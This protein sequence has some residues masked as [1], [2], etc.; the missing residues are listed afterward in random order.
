M[1]NARKIYTVKEQIENSHS[2]RSQVEK[3]YTQSAAREILSVDAETEFNLGKKIIIKNEIKSG[4]VRAFFFSFGNITFSNSKHNYLQIIKK[5][6]LLLWFSI[7]L[8]LLLLLL[9]LTFKPHKR[10]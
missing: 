4:F 6:N 1:M 9:K 7:L 3:R 5:K 2:H 8:L 10:Y